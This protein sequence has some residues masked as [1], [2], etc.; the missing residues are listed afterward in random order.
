MRDLRKVKN[1]YEFRLD[2]RQ[3]ALLFAGGLLIFVLLFT[4]GVMVGRDWREWEQSR[5]P[6]ASSQQPELAQVEEEGSF[7]EDVLPTLE[8]ATPGVKL[9]KKSISSSAEIASSPESP[10]EVEYTFYETLPQ[11]EPAKIELEAPP[12]EKEREA[13]KKIVEKPSP[14]EKSATTQPPLP[15]EGKYTVQ[16]SSFTEREK[17]TELVARL[18]KKKYPAYI[19]STQISQTTWYRVRVGRFATR[20][21]AE[22]FAL[23][24]KEKEKLNTFVTPITK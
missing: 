1:K 9:S 11:K 5:E 20:E 7:E 14:K 4:L 21:E 15:V 6:E 18:I 12:G 3:L 13:E 16:V 17:A 23:T 24:L 8:E 10:K 22:K 19:T 2:N